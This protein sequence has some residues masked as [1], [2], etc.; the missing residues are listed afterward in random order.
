M[1]NRV[2]H[3]LNYQSTFGILFFMC[4]HEN[5][6]IEFLISFKVNET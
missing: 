3:K 4:V 2:H 6:F 5:V 1:L